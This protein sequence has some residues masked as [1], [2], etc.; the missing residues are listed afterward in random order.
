M[1]SDAAA[2]VAQF[3]TTLPLVAADTVDWKTVSLPRR[4]VNASVLHPD[5]KCSVRERFKISYGDDV[6][7]RLDGCEQL[8]CEEQ[9]NSV[10]LSLHAA[11]KRGGGNLRMVAEGIAKDVQE[12]GVAVGLGGGLNGKLAEVRKYEIAAALNRLRLEGLL[13]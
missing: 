7:L 12:R 3:S 2:I 9:T 4:Q 11:A 1:T 13:N 10:L 8:A 5:W 6:T